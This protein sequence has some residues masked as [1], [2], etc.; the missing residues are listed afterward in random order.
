MAAVI[1]PSVGLAQQTQPQPD[2]QVQPQSAAPLQAARV[3]R[4]R[5][6]F[7][8][9]LRSVG[10]SDQ[11]KTQIQQLVAQYRQA[12]PAGSARD[13]QARKQLRDQILGVLTPQQQTELKAKLAQ[14]RAQRRATLVPQP[15]PTP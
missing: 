7:M 3:R 8:Q 2:A 13:P 6:F 1:V 12:H 5:G 15:S 4:H 10:L 9:A 11:Q 14:L